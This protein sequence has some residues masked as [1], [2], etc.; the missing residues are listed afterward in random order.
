MIGE[1]KDAFMQEVSD[2]MA[3]H[4]WYVNTSKE[5]G[6]IVSTLKSQYC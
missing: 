6:V 1:D 2:K 4:P 3:E 5:L